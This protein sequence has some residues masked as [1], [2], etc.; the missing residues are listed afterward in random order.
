MA[1]SVPTIKK[2]MCAFINSLNEPS[3]I[4]SF[5]NSV[6][7]E[8][9]QLFMCEQIDK[10]DAETVK[11]LYYAACPINTVLPGD[12]M[13]HILHFDEV[14]YNRTVCQT[15]NRLNK[16]NEGN[17]LRAAHNLVET[18]ISKMDSSPSEIW[19]P[20]P[21]RPALHPVEIQ[22]GYQGVVNS[23]PQVLSQC[24][25]RSLV[26]V[27]EYHISGDTPSF[28]QMSFLGMTPS[29][30]V[31]FSHEVAKVT[32]NASF[33]KLRIGIFSDFNVSWAGSK[34]TM[35]DC[36]INLNPDSGRIRVDS[37]ASLAI[38]NCRICN[39][40]AKINKSGYYP[41]VSGEQN[42]SI[43]I[44]SSADEVEIADSTFE[45]FERCVAIYSTTDVPIH[46]KLARVKITNN[47]FKRTEK[48]PIVE[49]TEG[50]QRA[51]IKDS[52]SCI[53]DGNS[54][55]CR[56]DGKCNSNEMHH[57][58]VNFRLMLDWLLME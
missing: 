39:Q 6:N 21:T 45:D 30:A 19:V 41:V 51:L 55:D 18:H 46:G 34:M 17:M 2:T 38:H 27:Y 9:L 43:V 29:S 12:V 23:I 10:M 53:I 40:D 26:L 20:H 48:Y 50:D 5:L 15:W 8:D 57:K 49:W 44:Q 56:Y 42:S 4:C 32:G 14:N 28:E 31:Y 47:V 1:L 36:T 7:F 25:E 16:Q 22:F 54:G 11:P 37:F 13:Q 24:D 33:E 52:E 35:K 3:A 58:P